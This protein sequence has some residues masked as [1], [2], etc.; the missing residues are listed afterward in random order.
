RP[1]FYANIEMAADDPLRSLAEGQAELMLDVF[2]WNLR[3]RR[4]I[5]KMDMGGWQ[6]YMLGSLTSSTVL[7]NYHEAHRTWHPYVDELI[8]KHGAKRPV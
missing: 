6:E 4:S 1:Y 5:S 7:L 3:R 2:D 8:E